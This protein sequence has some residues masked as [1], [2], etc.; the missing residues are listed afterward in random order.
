MTTSE[1]LAPLDVRLAPELESVVAARRAVLDAISSWNLPERVTDDTAL[2]VSELTTNAVLHARTDFNVSV[3][4][5]GSGLR[6]SVADM[7]PALPSPSI[8]RPEEL[9]AVRSMTGRGLALVAATSDRWGCDAVA[10]GKVVWAEVGTGRRRVEASPP[11]A[12]PL[13]P[14]RLKL[15]AAG[16]AAGLKEVTVAAGSG[17]HVHLVGVPV[18]LLIESNRHLTDLQ[19]EMQVIDLDRSGPQ[20]LI[21]L[22]G[23]TRDIEAHIGYLR[24]AGLADAKRAMARGESVVD[25]EF[26]V[27]DDAPQQLDLLGRLLAAARTKL[28]RRHLLTLPAGED[29]VAFR[30]WW[31]DEVLGQ[32]AGKAPEPCPVKPGDTLGKLRATAR[33]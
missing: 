6:V 29:I 9:L 21:E 32:L 8:N 10:G 33:P 30:L 13:A 1:D 17:R 19:R 16:V 12:F 20:E 5:L 18:S 26:D 14:E 3:S 28:A 7:D 11:P 15:T 27:P 2:V 24:E 23:S 31:R 4:R 22:A 25:V